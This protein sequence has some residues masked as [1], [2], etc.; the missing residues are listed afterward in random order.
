MLSLVVAKRGISLSHY[1]TPKSFVISS[2]RD[3]QI[4]LN[5][6]LNNFINTL[7]WGICKERE[8]PFK[9]DVYKG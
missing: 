7:L 4:P 1:G 3:L 2:E 8:K 9:K 6:W 5:S